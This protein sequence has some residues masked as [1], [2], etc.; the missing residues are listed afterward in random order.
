MYKFSANRVSLIP[1]FFF[2]FFYLI[3]LAR[4]YMDVA[5][6]DQIQILAGNINHMYNNDSTIQDYYYRPPFLLFFST[7][8]VYINCKLFSYNTYYENIVSALLLLFIA[9][10]YFKSNLIYFSKKY[11]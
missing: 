2:F 5:Y 8:L 1:I 3:L 6:M 10:Y 4:S 7:F 11:K 9:L